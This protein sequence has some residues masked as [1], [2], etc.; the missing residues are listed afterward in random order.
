MDPGGG[1]K[2]S[3]LDKENAASDALNGFR[4]LGPS[5]S[6]GFGPTGNR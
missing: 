4:V 1:G 2:P 6:L 3:A 5:C